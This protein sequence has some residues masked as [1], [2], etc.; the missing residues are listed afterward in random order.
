VTAVRIV[1]FTD[2]Y[3]PRRDGVITSVRT[4]VAA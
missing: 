3:L 1:H 4:L 2:T